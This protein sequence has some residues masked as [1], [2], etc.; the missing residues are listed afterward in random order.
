MYLVAQHIRKYEI[1]SEPKSNASVFNLNIFL[2]SAA[3]VAIDIG[4]ASYEVNLTLCLNVG[5][6]PSLRVSLLESVLDQLD[7]EVSFHLSPPTVRWC[8]L[9]V[10]Q[11]SW[12][13]HEVQ[14]SAALL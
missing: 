5:L 12:S 3:Q 9:P 11:Y 4:T 7:P 10:E 13:P 2:S 1:N 6:R 14:S 8:P